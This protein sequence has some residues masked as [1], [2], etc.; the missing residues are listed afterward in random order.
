VMATHSQVDH[1]GGLASIVRDFPTRE[2][3]T[4]GVTRDT[5]FMHRL[6]EALQAR[7]VPVRVVSSHDRPSAFGPCEVRI[8][9]PDSGSPPLSPP[10]AGKHLNNQSVVARM[11]CGSR[12]MLFT[13]DIE[14]EAEARLVASGLI[15]V[16]LMKV[17]HHGSRG[18]LYE[19]FLRTVRPELAVVSVGHSNPYG[20]PTSAMLALYERLHIPVLRTDRDGAITVVLSESGQQVSCEAGR[21]LT[22]VQP[23][24]RGAWDAERENLVRLWR[25]HPVC[26]NPVSLTSTS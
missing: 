12:S 8:V 4:T 18:S 6:D 5:V 14:E 20:H 25:T 2:F 23:G 21:R 26:S 16:N 7:Q 24:G 11:E 22:R 3:W 1:V 17:P 9:N 15:S 13:G 10:S 19:P